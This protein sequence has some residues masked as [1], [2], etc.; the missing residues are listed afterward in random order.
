MYNKNDR[1]ANAFPEV[2]SKNRCSAIL[3]D[4]FLV[5]FMALI[6]IF[7]IPSFCQNTTDS[8]TSSSTKPLWTLGLFNGVARLPLY[9][10][11][12]TYRIYALPLPYL[13]YRGKIIQSDREGLRGIFFRSESLETSISIFGNPPVNENDTAREGMG[14]LDPILE[15]GPALK[16]FF[17]GRAP[18]QYLY[19]SP[20]FRWVTSV[21]LPDNLKFSYQG[22]RFL[23]NLVYQNDA[24]WGNEQWGSGFKVGIDFADRR[25]NGYFYDVS[26]EYALPGRPAF[27]ADSGYG[28]FMV[29]GNLIYRIN[30]HFS[31]A[32]YG[33]WDAL[34]GAIYQDS[35][36][37]EENNNFTAA[38]AL[39][40]TIATSRKQVDARYQE[41]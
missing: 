9:R 29:S 33:R 20:A 5:V 30:H 24:I 25:Y 15:I 41:Q 13:I 38:A 32:V 7:P 23:I 34:A 4:V 12:A 3:R 2:D 6:L 28:G 40:W 1:A 36:L 39:I 37:V 11:S 10:G 14:D 17:L 21:G 22:W 27:D 19:L 35:P 16:W 8:A 31:I 26:E 18:R